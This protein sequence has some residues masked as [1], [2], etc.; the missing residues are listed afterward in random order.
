MDSSRNIEQGSSEEYSDVK[1][2]DIDSFIRYMEGLLEELRGKINQ[3]PKVDEEGRSD[4]HFAEELYAYKEEA[5]AMVAGQLEKLQTY[6]ELIEKEIKRCRDNIDKLH[7]DRNSLNYDEAKKRY[8]A[9][10]EAEEK[11]L[12]TAI[13]QKNSLIDLI[14]KAEELLSLAK[15]KKWPLGK[16]KRQDS[17]NPEAVLQGVLDGTLPGLQDPNRVLPRA[18][19]PA[20]HREVNDLM[21]ISLKGKSH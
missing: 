7:V 12:N 5:A 3:L 13:H 4:C 18:S 9:A 11:Q 15:G 14:K 20:F 10:K 16:P 17:F 8:D 21:S 19:R 1:L 6:L 2:E